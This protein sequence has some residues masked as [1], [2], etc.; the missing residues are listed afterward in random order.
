M[1]EL[2]DVNVFYGQSHALR[3]VSIQVPSGAAVALLGRN[4]AGKTTTLAAIG[5]HRPIRSG[6]IVLDDKVV[7]GVAPHKL[8]RSGLAF[9]AS[10]HSMFDD[11]TVRQNLE[12]ARSTKRK[13]R[14]TAQRVF[15]LFPK[16]VELQHRRA[17]V[18]SGGERQMLK[19]SQALLTNPTTL[20]L[21]E[22]T[23][24]LA[25][26]VVA[27]LRN[28][29]QNLLDTSELTV[30]LSEQ[31]VRF[32]RTL[33]HECYVLEKGIIR[34]HGTIDE[35]VADDDIRHLLGASAASVDFS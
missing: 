3:D 5:G 22:P 34:F 9:A 31:N 13:G 25:P 20:L 16:L 4:G 24:G 21:D 26:V 28:A 32:A 27:Q 35:V 18:L 30:V 10:G 6:S 17:G 11:L 23:E 12:V 33:V 2:Q 8:A 19:V 14:W 1:L 7:T 29:L 15:E